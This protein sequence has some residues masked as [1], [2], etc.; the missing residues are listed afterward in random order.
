MLSWVRESETMFPRYLQCLLIDFCQTFVIGASWDKDEL[1]R[2]WGQKLNG[3]GHIIASST[4]R[5][6]VLRFLV[7]QK[8]SKPVT[9]RERE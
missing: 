2:F 7:G 9:E 6:V 4:R 8:L 3:Q 1:I 5:S